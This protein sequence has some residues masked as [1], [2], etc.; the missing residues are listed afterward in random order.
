[1]M[2]F[3]FVFQTPRTLWT[4]AASPSSPLRPWCSSCPRLPSH[5]FVLEEIVAKN[6]FFS[7]FESPRHPSTNVCSETS[8]FS[9]FALPLVSKVR[10]PFFFPIT[11]LKSWTISGIAGNESASVVLKVEKSINRTSPEELFHWC[12]AIGF[13]EH[14]ISRCIL[15]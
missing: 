11:C 5:F 9:A 14:K 12:R 4:P 6:T 7:L 1:M 13:F 3:S 2:A 10:F 15:Q 8:V